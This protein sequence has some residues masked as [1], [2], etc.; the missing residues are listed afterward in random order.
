MKAKTNFDVT[1]NTSN[2]NAETGLA[3]PLW[4]GHFGAGI[5]LLLDKVTSTV[6]FD[7]K[8]MRIAITSLQA[9]V[10]MKRK[11]KLIA[12]ESAQRVNSALDQINKEISEG[13]LSLDKQVSIY[14]TINSRVAELAP[15][16][17]DALRIAHSHASQVAGDLK[18][19]IRDAYDT[20]DAVLRDLVKALVEKAEENVKTI[21]PGVYHN[22]LSQPTSFGHHLMAYVQ[23]VTRDLTRI[24]NA[25]RLMNESPYSSGEIAGN[26]FNLSREMVA[27][28]LDFDRAVSNSVDA[29]NSR[30]Y[31]I[32]FISISS[33]VANNISRLAN[34]MIT[35]HSS[36]CGYIS[37]AN[38][39]IEQSQVSPYRRDT[40]ALEAIRAKANKMY[41]NLF[42][43]LSTLHNLPL[44]FANDL[45]QISEMTVDTAES[46]SITLKAMAATIH[47]MQINRKVMKEAASHS[48]S[49]AFDLVD[50][51]TANTSLNLTQAEDKVRGIIEYAITRG[52]KLSLLELE[53]LQTFVPEIN[54]DVYS[55][56]IPSR[57]LIARRSGGGSNPVQI[58]K[59]IRAVKRKISA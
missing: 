42:G 1:V 19:F 47:N 34:E 14:D 51:L 25:R 59:A 52:K 39:F 12:E 36:Q 3:L 35:W 8:L 30:D 23:S 10:K 31:V 43:V 4:G 28:A 54:L 49:T 6:E 5:N 37:F 16:D 26:I 40:K 22:Q 18:C 33:I 56:L 53:E 45:M 13:K 46:L 57:T 27:K 11:R 48:Y 21:F 29:N 38:E 55:V 58:R 20:L 32:E 17:S 9:Q 44:Q 2:D 50:W 15:H 7:K 24:E 41:A